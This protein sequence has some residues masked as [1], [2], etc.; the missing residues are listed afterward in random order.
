MLIGRLCRDCS[1]VFKALQIL[2]MFIYA[3]EQACPELFAILSASGAVSFV[4]S[5]E[6]ERNSG[7]LTVCR[8]KGGRG[9]PMSVDDLCL[10]AGFQTCCSFVSG[11]S[12]SK[13]L[14]ASALIG[15]VH[16]SIMKH[17]STQLPRTV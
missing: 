4:S 13:M 8:G 11:R 1:V 12:C 2:L 3:A 16:C 9:E 5:N 6:M 10:P 17:N 15:V 7:L 14:S